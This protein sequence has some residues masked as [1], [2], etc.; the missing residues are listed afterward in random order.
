[1]KT[2]FQ[3]LALANAA[4]PM[5]VIILELSEPGVRRTGRSSSPQSE[6]TSEDEDFRD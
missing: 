3:F 4:S 5:Q 6:R 1:M 2:V